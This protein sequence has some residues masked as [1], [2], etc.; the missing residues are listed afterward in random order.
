MTLKRVLT[1]IITAVLLIVTGAQAA[2]ASDYG[3]R[4]IIPV[5]SDL[6]VQDAR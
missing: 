3:V 5:Q 1:S 4:R 2:G 6:M